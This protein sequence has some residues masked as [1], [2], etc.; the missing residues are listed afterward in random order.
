MT[1]HDFTEAQVKSVLSRIPYAK[2]IG[3]K[4]LLMGHELT[5]VMPYSQTVIGNPVLPAL[6]GGAVSA[7][8]ELAAILQL[9]LQCGYSKLPKPVGVNID[10]LRR[11]K[12]MDTYARALVAREGKRVA[13]VRV[14]AWQESFNEPISLLHG[15]FMAPRKDG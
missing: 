13:N 14:R 2:L 1:T 7:F 12:P 15:H 5:L 9:T 4:P 3:V 10:Y 8:M 11:G 6:H